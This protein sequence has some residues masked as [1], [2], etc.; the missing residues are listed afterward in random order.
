M[1]LLPGKR[2]S[3]SIYGRIGAQSAQAVERTATSADGGGS[4]KATD[5]K[6]GIIDKVLELVHDIRAAWY[7]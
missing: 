1:I 6:Q 3:V 7:L 2:C 4:P 5:I